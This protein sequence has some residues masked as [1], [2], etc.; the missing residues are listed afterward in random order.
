MS[1]AE[2]LDLYGVEGV[3]FAAPATVAQ[4]ILAQLGGQQFLT[5]TGAH[6][7]VHGERELQM[8]IPRRPGVGRRIFRVELA[9]DDTYQVR[10]YRLKRGLNVET[11]AAQDN[12]YAEMLAPVFERM[13]GLRT[14]L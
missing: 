11:C 12:V 1:E 7:L 9:A 4:T 3:N 8:Q 6:G 5:M 2:I 14:R 13:T 10:L